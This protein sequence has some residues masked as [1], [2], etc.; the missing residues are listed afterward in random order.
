MKLSP[1]WK[2]LGTLVEYYNDFNHICYFAH[3]SPDQARLCDLE[4]QA[5]S[6]KKGMWSEGGGSSTVRDL[7]YSIENPRNYVDSMHQ[8]PVNG[9]FFC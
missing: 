2:R 1:S 4:D 9:D 7:K 6:T 5:K 3:S 8:K